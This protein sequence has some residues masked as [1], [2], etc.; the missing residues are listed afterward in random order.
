MLLNGKIAMLSFNSSPEEIKR[1][2]LDNLL[3]ANGHSKLADPTF[4]KILNELHR[5][6]PNIF[7]EWINQYLDDE[8]IAFSLI[9]IFYRDNHHFINSQQSANFFTKLPPRLMN[10]VL[11]LSLDKRDQGFVLAVEKKIGKTLG[12]FLIGN[13]GHDEKLFN[14][15]LFSLMVRYNKR[16]FSD[17]FS[18]PDEDFKRL[19]LFAAEK[20]NIQALEHMLFVNKQAVVDIL[21]PDAIEKAVKASNFV[22]AATLLKHGFPYDKN[23]LHFTP[24]NKTF[25]LTH[26]AEVLYIQMEAANGSLDKKTTDELL[27]NIIK[28]N[29]LA[30]IHYL[31]INH[32]NLITQVPVEYIL[33][34]IEHKNIEMA[35]ILLQYREPRAPELPEGFSYDRDL[36]LKKVGH[37]PLLYSKQFQTLE[38]HLTQRKYH[39]LNDKGELVQEVSIESKAWLDLLSNSAYFGL[40][41][42]DKLQAPDMAKANQG[43]LPLTHPQCSELNQLIKTYHAIPKDNREKI[44][45]RIK[46]LRKIEERCNQIIHTNKGLTPEQ[47]ATVKNIRHVA[48]HKSKYLFSLR[49]L[50]QRTIRRLFRLPSIQGHVLRVDQPQYPQGEAQEFNNEAIADL[51]PFNRIFTDDQFNTWRQNA[52]QAQL[53]KENYPD[54]WMWLE[55]Q[56]TTTLNAHPHYQLPSQVK[57]VNFKEGCCTNTIFGAQESGRLHGTFLYNI[58]KDG[59]LY[60]LDRDTFKADAIYSTHN[61]ILGGMAVLSAGMVTF[62]EGK[63]IRFDIDSGHYRPKRSHLFKAIQLLKCPP[64]VFTPDAIAK[65]YGRDHSGMETPIAEVLSKVTLTGASAPVVK[66]KAEIKKNETRLIFSHLNT[67]HDGIASKTK[68]DKIKFAD[69]KPPEIKATTDTLFQDAIIERIAQGDPDYSHVNLSASGIASWHTEQ[70]SAALASNQNQLVYLDLSNNGLVDESFLKLMEAIRQQSSLKYLNVKDTP[71]SEKTLSLLRTLCE[72]KGIQL[73]AAPSLRMKT[74][75]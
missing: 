61:H 66:E 19:V 65:D 67:P 75:K 11:S 28:R 13:F 7:I 32:F 56:D 15:S 72:E 26:G 44:F 3:A 21:G 50:P 33:D 74:G 4:K 14:E 17:P 62:K 6:I 8:N 18:N 20:A 48:Q 71:L 52:E 5:K 37:L 69:S 22:L 53:R 24:D 58:G 55:T 49:F 12:Q 47:L 35:T 31:Q 42:T 36:L 23:K 25:A 41:S 30:A 40:L 39:H 43:K 16:Q 10:T 27:Q 29:D 45:E 64:E 34:A 59:N 57:K 2:I 63:I 68:M 51:D 60:I 70:L 46:T 9:L 38:A 1:F 73:E 54:F